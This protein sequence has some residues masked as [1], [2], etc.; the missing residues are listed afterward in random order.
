MRN[1]T[2]FA[3][4]NK[5]LD[6]SDICGKNICFVLRIMSISIEL[7]SETKIS[8]FNMS[9]NC[10]SKSNVMTSEGWIILLVPINT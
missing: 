4:I 5:E 9:T 1:G 2:Y 7:V 10:N 8:E 3:N 6:T